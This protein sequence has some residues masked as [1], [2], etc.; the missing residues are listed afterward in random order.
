M[1]TKK[2]V[3]DTK[4]FE[5]T[6]EDNKLLALNTFTVMKK[7]AKA[8]CAI[9]YRA[10]L[11]YIEG[12]EGVKFESQD[13]LQPTHEVSFCLHSDWDKVYVKIGLPRNEMSVPD[14]GLVHLSP[15]D[16][17]MLYAS[18]VEFSHAREHAFRMADYAGIETKI[19]DL[20][21]RIVNQP[22]EKLTRVDPGLNKYH[23][24]EVGKTCFRNF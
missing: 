17:L 19:P 6:D 22:G 10:L 3:Y 16:S 11:C 20:D 1:K 9:V 23:P 21:I 18:L 14:V 7:S 12:N 2:K 5:L 13:V 24:M 4:Y 15:R 8:V